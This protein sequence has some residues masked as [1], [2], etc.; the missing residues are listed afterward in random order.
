MLMATH[1]IVA[2][3][4]SPVC[5]LGRQVNKDV[6]GNPG[7]DR[8]GKGRHFGENGTTRPFSSPFGSKN[9][10]GLTSRFMIFTRQLRI[11]RLRVYI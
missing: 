7:S 9:Q 8:S 6:Q 10:A 2:A 4:L 11:V 3:Y 5:I 1:D